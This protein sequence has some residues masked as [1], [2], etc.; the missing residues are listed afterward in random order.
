MIAFL[1][2]RVVLKSASIAHLDVNGVGYELHMTTRS[3]ASLPASGDTVTIH[4]YLHVREDGITLFGFESTEERFAFEQLLTVSG[5]GPKVAL[6]TLSAISPGDLAQ[7]VTAE[8]AALIASVPGIG[9][10]TAQR[11]IVD[12]TGKLDVA[13]GSQA[14]AAPKHGAA[15]AEAREAL[16]SMG[17]SAA[18]VATALKGGTGDAQ[19]LV[20]YALGRIGSAL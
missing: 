2:G 3:L 10:K 8:D 11:I 1:T 15:M 16:I 19:A 17:F 9:K 13:A 7:A 20:R 5:V 14:T 6:S 4:T 18:E 12:L